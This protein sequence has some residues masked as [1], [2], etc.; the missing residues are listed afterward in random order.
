MTD[1]R[2]AGRW[3]LVSYSARADDGSV[4]YP[5]GADAQG[6]L[7]YTHGGWM[8]A[9]VSA[10]SRSAFSTEDLLGGSDGERAEAFSTYVA[11]CGSYEVSDDVVIHR[12][13][14][15][16]FPN[17]VGTEQSRYFHLEGAELVLRTPPLDAGGRSLVYEF[18]WRREEA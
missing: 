2:L 17:W 14:M 1:G 13:A 10:G 16:L 9:Q 8:S 7:V 11:Y 5:L 15:S 4:A 18:L 3:R 6:S 12:V